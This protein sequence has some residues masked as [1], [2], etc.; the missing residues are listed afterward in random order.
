MKKIKK[1]L[2]WLGLHNWVYVRNHQGQKNV[3]RCRRKHC[4]KHQTKYYDLPD[5]WPVK[6]WYSSDER[7]KYWKRLNEN[8]DFVNKKPGDV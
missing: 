2:C 8:K 6:T 7:A 1:L 3:R 5:Y 4:L